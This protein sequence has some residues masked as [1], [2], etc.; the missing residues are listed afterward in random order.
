MV[1]VMYKIKLFNQVLF[2]LLLFFLAGCAPQE[3]EPPNK[4][5]RE[6]GSA[7]RLSPVGTAL[8]MKK[9]A[10]KMAKIWSEQAVL[11]DINGLDLGSDGYNLANMINSKW[12]FTYTSPGKSE[13]ENSYVITF[14]GDG[15][16]SWLQTMG[17][18]DPA[19]NIESFSVDSNAAIKN[20]HA[21]GLKEGVV[22]TVEL[23]KKNGIITWV[24]GSK[25]DKDAQTYN[26]KKI[27][28][29]SGAVIN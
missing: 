9:N 12:I 29:V 1:N 15:Q 14:G 8:Q 3:I 2:V 16:V 19:N 21:G 26:I 7:P 6:T 11:M 4:E 23:N 20:S 25:E 28:A 18:Y 24:I 17:T 22:Y 10:D 27:D 5:N 13:L